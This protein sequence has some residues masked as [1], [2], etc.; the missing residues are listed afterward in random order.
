MVPCAW[1][2]CSP[3]CREALSHPHQAVP[4]PHLLPLGLFRHR[5][6]LEAKS[7]NHQTGHSRG[8]YYRTSERSHRRGQ[9]QR[10]AS[11]GVSPHTCWLHRLRCGAPSPVQVKETPTKE[12]A[13][14]DQAPITDSPVFTARTAPPPNRTPSPPHVNE[15]PAAAPSVGGSPADGR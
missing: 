7:G 5:R 6:D 10:P 8:V 4:R 2:R 13:P 11:E 9:G 3:T 12:A 14:C 15:D 1:L